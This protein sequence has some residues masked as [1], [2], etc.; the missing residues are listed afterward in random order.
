MLLFIPCV[1]PLGTHSR[2]GSNASSQVFAAA[3]PNLSLAVSLLQ[4]VRDSAPANWLLHLL[5]APS[6]ELTSETEARIAEHRLQQ[7]RA[8][9]PLLSI[10]L[11][12]ES[13]ASPTL[14]SALAASKTLTSL[15]ADHLPPS[16]TSALALQLKS[17]PTLRAV[18]HTWFADDVVLEL[19]QSRTNWSC[20]HLPTK[21]EIASEASAFA[22]LNR[23]DFELHLDASIKAADLNRWLSNPHLT[24]LHL[25][26]GHVPAA[27][28][29][30]LFSCQNLTSL[31]M[32]L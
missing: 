25:G 19:L 22:A 12:R 9:Y 1:S 28:Y 20:I 30:A 8:Q 4:S 26:T 6:I 13:G 32:F 17:S 10:R 11:A 5:T 15:S 18:N 27:C 21:P 24:S 7:S 3:E 23:T 16:A 14:I 2:M 31:V 29:D